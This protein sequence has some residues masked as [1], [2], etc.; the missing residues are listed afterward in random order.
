MHFSWVLIPAFVVL[1][2]VGAAVMTEFVL[3]RRGTDG[4]RASSTGED[5]LTD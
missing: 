5:G 2:A 3:A 4:P 1:Y